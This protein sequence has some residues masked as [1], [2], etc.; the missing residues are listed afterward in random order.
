[1]SR[2]GERSAVRHGAARIDYAIRRSRRRR[3]VA[4]TVHPEHGVY[5]SAPARLSVARLDRLVRAKA[6]WI[7]RKLDEQRVWRLHHPGPRFA[8][9]ETFSLLGTP[10]RLHLTTDNGA[11]PARADDGRL[12]VPLPEGL[13]PGERAG[14]VR[15]ALEAWYRE[16]A[17]AELPARV[18]AWSPAV[19]VAEPR[20]IVKAQRRRWGSCSPRG[21]LRL[22]WRLVQA[23]AAL[24]DYVVVHELAHLHHPHHQP[25]FWAL[26]GRVLPDYGAR[27]KALRA[28]GALLEW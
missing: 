6:P 2:S 10:L 1:M 13:P 22:N 17:A 3:T 15:A 5:C 28:L 14:R 12:R 7:L 23:P 27:R 25:A 24:V 16:R 19:G 20:V 8:S 21:V 11:G 4:I 18:R 9:G 26:V